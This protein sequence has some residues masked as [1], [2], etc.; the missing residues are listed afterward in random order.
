LASVTLA[1]VTA[2]L[3]TAALVALLRFHE[4]QR[5]EY[6]ARV[7]E[8][9][10]AVEV[11]E[12]EWG[13][14]RSTPSLFRE[15]D[16]VAARV[17]AA[18]S[19]IAQWENEGIHV[20]TVLEHDYP[21]NLQ[22]VHDRPPLIFIRGR[23]DQRDSRSV[24]V[25]GSRDA[26]AAGIRRA[27]AV[28][29]HLVKNGYAVLSGLAAGIDTASHES[30]LAQGGRTLAVIGT[31][32][33]HS[34]PLQ[35]AALQRVIASEGAVISRFWPDVRPRRANFPMRNALMS[36]LARATVIVEASH[37]S[38]ARTQARFALAQ[39]RPVFLLSPLL[40]QRWANELAARPGTHVVESPEEIIAVLERLSPRGVLV[41]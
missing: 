22:T 8:C 28:V 10:S 37:K 19:E 5:Q 14:K 15:D 35:N 41:A 26:S 4:A 39:G 33:R 2:N 27:K 24:A 40:R 32:L 3:E 18:A 13:A 31:G 17:A 34:Y 36:G 1:A 16:D 20:L 30:A 25:I 7:E 12:G 6:A 38:G 9:G 29:K 21:Q 11:L 23:L